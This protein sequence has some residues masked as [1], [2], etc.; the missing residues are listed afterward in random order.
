MKAIVKNS[1]VGFS[2]VQFADFTIPVPGPQQLRI[3]LLSAGLNRRDLRVIAQQNQGTESI[4]LGSDGAGVV[5]EIGQGVNDF[6]VGD[7]VIIHP[8]LKWIKNTPAPPDDYEILGG[9]S[10]G[11][12]A[13]YI[14][15]SINHVARK[16]AYLSWLEAGVLPLAAVTAYR[17]LFSRGHA[18][19]N[20][21]ILISGAGG[22]VATYLVQFAKAIGAHVVVTSRSMKK[23]EMAIQLGADTAI[24]TTQDWLAQ[25][26]GQK[27]DLVVDSIGALAFDSCLKVLKPGGTLV[28]FGATVGDETRFDIRTFFYGQFNLKGSTM[29]SRE[30]FDEM[31][32]FITK[33]QI[34]PV[35]DGIYPLS[36]AKYALEKLKEST[37]FGKIG[38]RI[39]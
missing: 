23:R 9:P 6:K 33:H 24:D 36:E 1:A 37:N 14:V 8:A 38:L 30:E 11:T 7:E 35:I 28:T 5:D 15:I 34:H 20:Q 22:G 4:I 18:H 13:Q 10:N 25:L 29:G 32:K 3:R 39:D 17:A 27:V 21:S 19:A 2:N 31:L 26:S 12:F 16:P